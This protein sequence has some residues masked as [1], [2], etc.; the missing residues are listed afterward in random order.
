MQENITYAAESLLRAKE[1]YDQLQ[2]E[3]IYKNFFSRN[4]TTLS[5]LDI[6]ELA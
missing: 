1:Q 2:V 3:Q 4:R 5:G 6:Y